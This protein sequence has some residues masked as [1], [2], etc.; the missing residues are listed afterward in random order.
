[1]SD[2]PKLPDSNRPRFRLP[3][4]AVMLLIIMFT[5]WF[6]L[7]IPAIVNSTTAS[8]P[9]EIPYSFFRQQIE[10]GSVA[11][12]VMQG[13]QVSGEFNT[14]VTWPIPDSPDAK[15]IPPATSNRFTTTLP[16]IPDNEL[17]PLLAKH[18]VTL[19][20]SDPEPSP[21]IVLLLN[22]GPLILIGLC[23]SGRS[24]EPASSRA[25]SSASGRA[26]PGAITKNVHT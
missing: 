16:P 1:M 8:P 25:A 22:W 7:R 3:N 9:I 12:I 17:L 15:Q 19:I 6:I 5:A 24:T 20:A 21:L 2:K 4:W 11:R 14:N 18:N 10:A 13:S 23:Y 26:R